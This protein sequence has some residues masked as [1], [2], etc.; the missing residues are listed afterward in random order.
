MS[1]ND[2]RE[3]TDTYI[4]GDDVQVRKIEL[5]QIKKLDVSAAANKLPIGMGCGYSPARGTA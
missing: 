1:P 4:G 3:Y 2:N 5:D